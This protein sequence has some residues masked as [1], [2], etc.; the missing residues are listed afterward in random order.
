MF[1]EALPVSEKAFALAPWHALS[2]GT[3]AEVLARTGQPERGRELI[4]KLGSGDKYGTSL[5]W[6]I[7]HTCCGEMDLAADGYD[8]AL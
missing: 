2:V 4:Q 7:F 8:K 6:A 3:Y 1:V 5:G